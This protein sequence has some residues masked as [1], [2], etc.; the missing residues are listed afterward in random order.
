MAAKAPLL[1]ANDATWFPHVAELRVFS[2][3]TLAKTAIRYYLHAI[4]CN[5]GL[6]R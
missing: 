4:T 2:K 5:D 3:F 1:C 6:P